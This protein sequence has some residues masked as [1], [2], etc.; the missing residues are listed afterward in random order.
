MV[1]LMLFF[2]KGDPVETRILIGVVYAVM[3]VPLTYWLDGMVSVAGRR[4]SQLEQ[5]TRGRPRIPR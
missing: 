3:F 5:H 4:N 2:L 1:V